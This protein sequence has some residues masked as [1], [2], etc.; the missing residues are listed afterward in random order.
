LKADSDSKKREKM[1]RQLTELNIQELQTLVDYSFKFKDVLTVE[2]KKKMRHFVL[3]R[4]NP[5][6]E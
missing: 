4:S 5:N 3:T 1:L 2:Q 6:L